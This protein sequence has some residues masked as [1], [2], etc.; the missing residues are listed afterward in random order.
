MEMHSQVVQE[1]V[2]ALLADDITKLRELREAF[3]AWIDRK[4][5]WN[6][7][8]AADLEEFHARSGEIDQAS[9]ALEE[10]QKLLTPVVRNQIALEQDRPVKSLPQPEAGVAAG[11]ESRSI[12][13]QFVESASYK[14]WSGTGMVQ[15]PVQLPT[16]PWKQF[17]ATMTTS[18]GF[19]PANNRTDTVIFSAQRRPVVADIIPNTTANL[20]VIKYMEET[21]FTNAAA[22]VAENAQKPEATLVFTERSVN[23][24]VIAVTLPVTEQQ[25]KYV[26]FLRAQ[27]DNRLLLMLALTEETQLLTGN[28]TSPNLRGFLNVSGIQTQAKGSDPVPDAVYKAFTRVRYTGWAEPSAVIMHPNDWQDVRLL[29]TADGIYIWGNPSEPGLERI[30]G[31]P[32][33]ITPAITENTALTGDFLLYSEIVRAQEAR[34]TAGWVNDDF[35]RNKLTLRGE[36]YVSLVVYRPAAFCTITGI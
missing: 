28:G 11:V 17:K 29:R 16:D 33:V 15:V 5:G 24:E 1:R 31:K 10:K 34:I 18:A 27:I 22:P 3:K 6:N 20:Q 7:L 23:M 26:P 25:L 8:T 36:E 4:G 30:W 35:I 14:G 32:V 21:T 9:K 2:N 13:D 12:G 19:A